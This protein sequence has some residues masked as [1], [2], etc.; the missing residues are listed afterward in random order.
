MVDSMALTG[1]LPVSGGSGAGSTFLLS[2]LETCGGPVQS[3]STTAR[4]TEHRGYADLGFLNTKSGRTT[5]PR[6]T[7]SPEE[8]GIGNPVAFELTNNPTAPDALQLF[9]GSRIQLPEG[10][11]EEGGNAPSSSASSPTL[12]RCSTRSPASDLAGTAA[13]NIPATAAEPPASGPLRISQHLPVSSATPPISFVAQVRSSEAVAA[14]S[15]DPDVAGEHKEQTN[16]SKPVSSGR[17]TGFDDPVN[18]SSDAVTPEPADNNSPVVA[19]DSAPKNH[20]E[21]VSRDPA[22]P[23]AQPDATENKDQ[24]TAYP[25]ALFGV[26]H[27]E[28][29]SEAPAVPAAVISENL[30]RPPAPESTGEAPQ[31]SPSAPVRE[32][33]LRL[34][35]RSAEHVDLR[36]VDQ[37]QGNV[38][39]SVRAGDGDLSNRLQT[40]KPRL[41]ESLHENGLESE[42]WSPQHNYATH[43]SATAESTGE[44]GRHHSGSGNSGQQQPQQEKRQSAHENNGFAWDDEIAKGVALNW[45]EEES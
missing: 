16:V 15:T 45:Q 23:S 12:D 33:T 21:P 36:V 5:Q 17:A 41:V 8:Q 1:S 40:D 10:E 6:S 22:P 25:P 19:S 26:D 35:E 43:N 7:R 27:R 42:V 31:T 30:S 3:P 38:R 18:D 13:V 32:L 4:G 34:G 24:A 44:D 29:T 11:A 9:I 28:T 20:S 37:G 14:P 39:I 2:L